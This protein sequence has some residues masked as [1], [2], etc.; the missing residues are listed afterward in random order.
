ML[1]KDDLRPKSSPLLSSTP[2]QVSAAK[3][4]KNIYS[5]RYT[6][7]V[8]KVLPQPGLVAYWFF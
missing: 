3:K 2:S 1:R 7:A 4:N 6:C 5:Q 8:A